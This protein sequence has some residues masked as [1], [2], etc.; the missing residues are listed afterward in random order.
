MTDIDVH[1]RNV[2]TGAS[3]TMRVRNAHRLEPELQRMFAEL[4]DAFEHPKQTSMDEWREI[5]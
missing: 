1:K 2:L 3:L 5:A 4:E